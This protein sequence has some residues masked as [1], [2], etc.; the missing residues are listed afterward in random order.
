MTADST[1]RTILIVD[2]DVDFLIPLEAQ[3][4]AKG[5]DVISANGKD[6]ALQA[7][8]GKTVD[9]AVLDLMM[10]H[11]DDGF[12]LCYELKRINAELPVILA[13][14]VA[15]ETGIE[16]DAITEGE[17]GWIKADVVLSKPLRMEQLMREV[18][19]LLK[20]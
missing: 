2:D 17:R 3:L 15:S 1:Q 18:D 9:L 8:E 12:A 6:E 7:I 16:F 14:G 4:R 20:D 5:F 11:M 10:E 13:T 19:R